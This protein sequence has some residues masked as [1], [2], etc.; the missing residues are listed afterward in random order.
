VLGSSSIT[1]RT[2]FTAR[3]GW[4]LSPNYK[5]GNVKS[6]G[7]QFL[8]QYFS[9]VDSTREW[10]MREIAKFVSI[11]SVM[12]VPVG[13]YH[14]ITDELERWIVE[15]GVDGFN[16]FSLDTPIDYGSFVDLVVPELQRRRLFPRSTRRARCASTTLARASSAS[17]TTIRAPPT[18]ATGARTRPGLRRRVF[19]PERIDAPASGVT[20][21]QPS[22]ATV[23]PRAF[24]AKPALEP[25]PDPSPR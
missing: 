14:R 16:Y 11:A 18:A 4:V 10:T 20:P 7:M 21:D 3:P 12:P 13:N 8:A 1:L 5:I 24:T 25:G 23:R 15:G 22:D 9:S 17:S 19:P 2:S 6:D